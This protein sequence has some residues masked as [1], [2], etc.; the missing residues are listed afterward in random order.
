MEFLKTIEQH[1]QAGAIFFAGALLARFAVAA[2][3]L[4]CTAG[5]APSTCCKKNRK[6]APVAAK[7]TKKIYFGVNPENPDANVGDCPMNPPKERCDDYF[8]LRDDTRQR[9]DVLRY[10]NEEN[11][12]T[13]QETSHLKCFQECLYKEMIGHLKETD[14]EVPYRHGEYLYYSRTIQGKSYRIHCRKYKHHNAD[15]EVVLDI[16]KVAEGKDYTDVQAIK[17]SPSHRAAAYAV[18]YTGY[19]TYDIRVIKDLK[20]REEE[21]CEHAVKNSNGVITWGKDDSTFFYLTVDSEHR[22]NKL[23][24]HTVGTAQSDDILIHCEDDARFWLHV[25]KSRDGNYLIISSESKETSEHH[26]IDLC[27]LNS[28]ECHRCEVNKRKKCILK[29]RQGLRYDIEHHNGYFYIVTNFNNAVNN[30]LVR[31]DACKILN[32]GTCPQ[33][34]CELEVCPSTWEEIRPYNCIE[35]IDYIL[36]FNERIAIFGRCNGLAHLWIMNDPKDC[37]CQWNDVCFP[38]QDF[39]LSPGDN[40]DYNSTVLRLV[41]SS[42]VTPR[43]VLDYEFK[44]GCTLIRKMQEVPGYLKQDYEIRRMEA[45]SSTDP[46]VKIPISLVFNRKVLSKSDG[47]F[48][49]VSDN[50]LYKAPVLLYGY[51]SYGASIDPSFDF[52]RLALLDRGVVF[53]IAHIR[54]GGEYGRS[55]YEN[56]G[57]Y[58]NKMN[59]FIDFIDC[60]KHLIAT[61]ITV[62]SQLAIVGRSAGGLLIGS[63]INLYPNLFK[64]AVADVP[65]VD[66][67]T[68][69]R[70]ATIPL[71]VTEWEEWGNPNQEEFYNYMSK[72]SPY[73]NVKA[74]AYPALLVTAGLNDPRVAYWEPA[75]WVAKLRTMKTDNNPLLLKT[76]MSSGHFSA[77]DRYKYVR[78]TAFEYAFIL[79]QL[80]AKDKL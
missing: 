61:Q 42:F 71:T 14:E 55:W 19:E 72:Y 5:D 20:T 59:T 58:L 49:Y 15:E 30:R 50:C 21:N 41:Y 23:Y 39:S 10:L 29:R 33:S 9:T 36:P 8:W 52:K 51:G 24:L 65:F 56:Q 63:T 25:S 75:K 74:Q 57:K 26:V 37:P 35:Q 11:E 31:I 43:Q 54:G 68:T 46:C 6:N 80:R 77:S 3:V 64:V 32:V 67:L 28:A 2:G 76:D 70:D 69:M 60:A 47:T 40:K 73:D 27:G 12:Y 62:P 4:S 22:P 44:T 48:R 13:E 66:V 78:E 38:E 79:D 18:D 7:V 17:V 53:A 1:P 45:C 16:N 34:G